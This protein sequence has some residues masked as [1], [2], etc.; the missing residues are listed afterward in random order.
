MTRRVVITGVGMHTP[1]GSDPGDVF[2]SILA[3][4]HGIR[5]MPDWAGIDG[6]E[7]HVGAPVP[8]FDGR[9][10]PRKVRRTMGRVGVLAAS[11]AERAVTSAG[12]EPQ[13]LQS[14]RAAVIVGSTAGSASDRKSVV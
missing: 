7:T 14:G 9:H 6:L 12:L 13:V 1:L 4:R 2:E 5:R 11:A 3:G 8:D 10:L